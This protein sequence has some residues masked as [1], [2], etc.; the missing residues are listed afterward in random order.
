MNNGVINDDLILKRHRAAIRR[1][2]KVFFGYQPNSLGRFGHRNDLDEKG[3][4]SRYLDSVLVALKPG[5]VHSGVN[6]PVF[7][8]F[9]KGANLGNIYS[10]VVDKS[11]RVWWQ[12]DR[13]GPYANKFVLSEPG[14]FDSIIAENTS[15]GKA[16]ETA[17]AQR[18]LLAKSP[19]DDLGKGLTD[20]V[21]G[22]GKTLSG[23]GK[24]FGVIV[25]IIFI[26]VVG[27]SFYQLNKA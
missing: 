18:D 26:A 23:L 24:N 12:I 25:L 6:G 1:A 9:P 5:T 2:E 20:I 14:K 16:I 17:K 8:S 15:S 19:L 3:S 10:Y 13:T 22:A 11:G 4:A 7:A 21:T 27:F